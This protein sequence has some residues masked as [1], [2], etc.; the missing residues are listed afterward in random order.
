[1]ETL[2]VAGIWL[3]QF[4]VNLESRTSLGAPL[5]ATRY[6]APY[7]GQTANSPGYSFCFEYRDAR[8]GFQSRFLMISRS[9]ISVKPS[10]SRMVDEMRTHVREIRDDKFGQYHEHLELPGTYATV[11]CANEHG[12]YFYMLSE[13]GLMIP[14]HWYCF[15]GLRY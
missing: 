3:E 5:P 4:A 15:T 1:M 2:T 12:T 9:H 7:F 8:L 6:S 14:K 13:S 10:I 11:R